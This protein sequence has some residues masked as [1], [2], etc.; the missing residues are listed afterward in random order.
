MWSGN[1]L[2]YDEFRHEE[3]IKF[4]A[5]VVEDKLQLRFDQ[6]EKTIDSHIMSLH[7]DGCIHEFKDLS[8]KN[9]IE[10][11]ISKATQLNKKK[12]QE[13]VRLEG[14]TQSYNIDDSLAFNMCKNVRILLKD[15]A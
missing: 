1:S 2:V 9:K 5:Q 15:G 7:G 10:Y 6:I 12:S 3:E 8:Y 14:M 4:V 11:I 13:R